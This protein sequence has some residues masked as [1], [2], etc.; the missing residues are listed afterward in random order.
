MPTSKK[1]KTQFKKIEERLETFQSILDSSPDAITYF[2]SNLNL[3]YINQAGLNRFID[4]IK[5]EAIIGKHMREIF[6]GIEHT[7]RF[8]K[9]KNVLETGEPIIIEEYRSLP[10]FG[11]RFISLR[12]FKI[13]DGLGLISR[14]I[15]EY[16]KI[17]EALRETEQQA[18]TLFE[19]IPIGL[20]RT[21]PEGEILAANPAFVKYVGFSSFEEIASKNVNEIAS[22]IDY[23]RERYMKELSDKDEVTGLEF[24]MKKLDGTIV[25]SRENVRVIRDYSGKII[26]YEGSFEDITDQKKIEKALEEAKAKYQMLLEKQNEAVVFEDAHGVITYANPRI[27]E[28]LGYTEEEL[29]GQHWSFVVHPDFVEFVKAE[30]AKRPMGVSGTYE[31]CLQAKD[32]RRIPIIISATPIF[33][34]LGEFEGILIFNTD[35]TERKKLEETLRESE[36]AIK[37]EKAKVETNLEHFPEGILILEM[38]GDVYLSNHRFKSYFKKIYQQKIPQSINEFKNL[39]NVF[40]NTIAKLFLKK[41]RTLEVIE[42]KKGFYLE[43]ASSIVMNTSKQP[44][45]FS[46]IVRDVSPYVEFDN[47]RNKFVSTVSHELRT[48]TNAIQLGIETLKKYKS[49]LSD[50]DREKLLDTIERSTIALS[51]LI[52][53]LLVISRIDAQKMQIKWEEYYLYNI[54][55]EVQR[56]LNPILNEK[57]SQLLIEGNLETE[58]YGDPQRVE[59]I[60]RILLDNA[61]KYSPSNSIIRLRIKANYDGKL[62]PSSQDG[63]L[64]QV[65]DKGRGI[66]STD[67]PHLFERFFRAGNV[68]DIS[69]T[70]LG[71]TIAKELLNLHGGQ[72]FVESEVGI[73]STFSIF[74]PHMGNPPKIES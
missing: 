45:N 7:D 54:I 36:A 27:L 61:I 20:Y 39:G 22:M 63:T 72:I 69:G 26:C 73:G 43:L 25:H 23:P 46:I 32:G 13:K 10:R 18:R 42:P 44:I 9:Y 28:L 68:A 56:Q 52:E 40:G 3:L 8:K 58:L 60:I 31:S 67:L 71:L 34:D 47:I 70:G 74:L 53:D 30:S 49:L 14:D 17:K 16:Q 35:I 15:T 64:L 11:D 4:E 51:T 19:N 1:R 62:N 33:S 57:N 48:P 38:N 37:N 55:N 5:R 66:P 29:I 6:P 12:V 65:V 2:D 50:K 21:T 41:E 59:Q 24:Q